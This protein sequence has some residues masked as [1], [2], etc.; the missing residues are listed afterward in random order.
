M[1][2]YAQMLETQSSPNYRG[3]ME[4]Y[5][6]V[7]KMREMVTAVDVMLKTA[8][9]CDHFG[10]TERAEELFM[11]V[12]R[13]EPACEEAY[14]C[15]ASYLTQ[16]KRIEDANACYQA[17]IRHVQENGEL[18]EQYIQ[19]LKDINEQHQRGMSRQMQMHSRE[20]S[21]NQLKAQLGKIRTAS[22]YSTSSSATNTTTSSGGVGAQTS[23]PYTVPPSPFLTSAK[24][25]NDGGYDYY[26]T[27][28]EQRSKK[29]T[30]T[31][32][33]TSS[34]SAMDSTNGSA[35]KEEG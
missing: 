27:V 26:Q 5:E 11:S 10:R 24:A 19:F 9:L 29:P 12:L 32:T 33:V 2:N 1:G 17:G 7:L 31:A 30:T 8:K 3:A 6:S 18:Q 20:R 16:Q 35:A 14:V 25:N 28:Q 13:I 34:S 23:K 15:F 4:Q 22:A 21:Q